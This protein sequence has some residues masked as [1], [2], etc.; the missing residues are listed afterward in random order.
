VSRCANVKES[1][2]EMGFACCGSVFVV[3]VARVY[4]TD[5]KMTYMRSGEALRHSRP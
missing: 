2:W 4:A 5:V 1:L 3:F